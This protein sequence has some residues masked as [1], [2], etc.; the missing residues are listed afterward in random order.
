MT[1]PVKRI[2][3][4][5]DGE[6]AGRLVEQGRKDFSFT[7]QPEA[8]DREVSLTMPW[9]DT[10]W[11]FPGLHPVFAQN[12]PEGYLK[13]VLARTVRKLHGA[14]DLALLTSLGPFQIGRL[15]YQLSLIHI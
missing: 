9:R 5:V 1:D 15:G 14:S 8:A 13:D 12:L 11:Q 7:Y 3:V 2:T 6:P 10:S 4:T